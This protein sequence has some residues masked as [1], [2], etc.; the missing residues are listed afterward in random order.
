MP[1]SAW[2]RTEMQEKGTPIS[3]WGFLSK[4]ISKM[5]KKKFFKEK[6]LVLESW[7]SKVV[8]VFWFS[9]NCQNPS[10]LCPV[11]LKLGSPFKIFLENEFFQNS[12][13]ERIEKLKRGPQFQNHW[14]QKRGVLTVL[15]ELKNQD[16]FWWPTFRN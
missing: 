3:K 4:K 11:I 13:R 16:H 15:T 14:T 7:S 6:L 2:K 1:S 8:L 9:Q 10:F 12:T 5:V